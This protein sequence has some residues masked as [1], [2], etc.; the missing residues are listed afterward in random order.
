MPLYKPGKLNVLADFASRFP[1]PGMNLSKLDREEI[2]FAMS[3]NSVEDNQ[4]INLDL[5]RDR[6]RSD[7]LLQN[8]I[9]A[10]TRECDFSKQPD[11]RMFSS[12]IGS[13]NFSQGL[14]TYDGRI[15]IPTC[16]QEQILNILHRDHLGIVKMKQLSRRY[17]FWPNL[18]KMIEEF[19]KRCDVCKSWNSDRSQKIFV[20][21]PVPQ[22]PFDRVHLD[23][24]YCCSKNFL[25]LVDA[26]SRWLEVILMTNTTAAHLIS[27]LRPI[28]SRFGDPRTLVTDNGPPFGSEEFR[29]FCDESRITL[30]HSPP[31]NP[32][33]NGLAERW[34][35]TTKLALKKALAQRYSDTALQRVL[36]ALR[37]TPSVDDTI[38]AQRFL[39]FQPRTVLEKIV[40]TDT[41][42]LSPDLSIPGHGLFE[43][44]EDVFLKGEGNG[45]RTFATVIKRLGNVMY[46][47]STNGSIRTAHANQLIRA[48]SAHPTDLGANHPAPTTTATARPQ[49]NRKPPVRY[50]N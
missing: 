31:Y 50:C 43:P 33:S 28:F 16:L 26:F 21:W 39:A 32:Q 30:L 12:V 29:K 48:N 9:R 6:T 5:I 42:A 15:V 24:F 23:F 44:G 18:N 46:E 20:S 8:L 47:V 22:K 34:V 13:L 2:G 38:P 40:E 1:G 19:A 3:V 36:C 35:Q 49:R 4:D 11:L 7:P 45:K 25:I 41:D 37:N 10:I 27:A 17:F 14:I